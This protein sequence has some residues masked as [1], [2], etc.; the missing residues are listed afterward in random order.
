M[1]VFFLGILLSVLCNCSKSPDP[2]PPVPPAPPAPTSFTVGGGTINIVGKLK[3]G[4]KVT[5]DQAAAV[6][7]TR[8]DQ[9]DKK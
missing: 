9:L 7:G 8:V 3:P 4:A 5:A 1:R 2:I 6:F